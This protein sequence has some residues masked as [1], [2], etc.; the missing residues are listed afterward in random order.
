M[1]WLIW[2]GAAVSCVGLAGLLWCIV[3]VARAKRAGLDDD[4][5]RQRVRRVLPVNLAALL[6]SALGLIVVVVGIMLA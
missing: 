1:D 4:A 2:L 6:T 3:T 5:L